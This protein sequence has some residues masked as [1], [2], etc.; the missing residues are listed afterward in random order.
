MK[1]IF[2]LFFVIAISINCFAQTTQ[3][4]PMCKDIA[5]MEAKAKAKLFQ[6]SPTMAL[7]NYD[8][9]HQYC[10]WEI[11]PAVNKIKGAI[12][13]RF[14]P[15]VANF[16]QMEFDL[17]IALTVDSVKYHTASVPFTHLTGD[18]LT[19]TLPA[20][21]PAGT[22]DSITVYYQG[23]PPATGF[24]SFVKS[25]HNGAPI[26][27][28]LSEPFGA[29][30]WWPCKQNLLDKIDSIDIV[31]KVPKGNRVASNG[32]LISET[33]V[34]TDK[35]FHW[36]STYPIATYLVGIAV[37][38]YAFY[39]DYVPL[40]NNDSLE[41][42]NY[43]YPENLANVQ[44]ETKDIVKI[45]SLYDS[46]TITY[47][48]NKE[49][50]GHAQFGWGGGMEHQTMSFMVGFGF[51]L[52]AHECAHQWFGD[53]ITCG[54][55][56]DVWLNEGF[57]T[58]FEGLT[59]ERYF[60]GNWMNWKS[61]KVDNIT[62][63]PGGSVRCT[64]TLTVGRVFDSRLTYNK[65]SYLLHMLRWKLGDA[66]FFNGLK[67]YLNDPLLIEKFATTP[68][69]KKHLEAVSGKDLTVFFNQ[70][71][72]N[73][74]FPT[75]QVIWSQHSDSLTVT[76]N[77]TQSQ[78]SVFFFEMPVP[79]KFVGDLKD[80]TIVFD[81]TVSGQVF[82]TKVN[83]PIK[84]VLFDPELWLISKNNSVV[85]ID[86][87]TENK[88]A[89][90]LYPVPSRNS[91]TVSNL[92]ENTTITNWHV[93]DALGKTVLENKHM[94]SSGSNFTIDIQQLTKGTYLLLIKTDKGTSS[95]QFIKE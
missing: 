64:D 78:G 25:A 73:E 85:G 57:A 38:N 50:Y 44:I 5:A 39:S 14:K 3:M 63:Q 21:I 26:I 32:L 75:Y 65:G 89:I 13:T 46:L 1:S 35:I 48:F 23:T 30:D 12:T 71:Y 36:K 34:G 52:M 55:W 29:K 72:Y 88:L 58:Y 84:T 69:L 86:A 42:L 61:S 83:F 79:I 7:N 15:T 18:L 33:E 92:P 24:G 27:W 62:S 37:T 94:K 74:G 31:V 17:S 77:Q 56:E 6:P 16:T 54:S 60:P 66:N 9:V 67:N 20:A 82:K 68:D 93:V 53:Y 70:W 11:D 2:H 51:S 90:K 43:V 10:Y 41:V 95:G 49:K 40:K 28:T 91:L 87:V 8:V 47:P 19:I 80:T 22:L 45:I 59:V 4:P 81:H 76:L